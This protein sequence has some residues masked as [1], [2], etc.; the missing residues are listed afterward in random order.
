MISETSDGICDIHSGYQAMR[1][2]VHS[3]VRDVLSRPGTSKRNRKLQSMY[4][5]TN[6][7]ISLS[8]S[9]VHHDDDDPPCDAD[10]VDTIWQ[11][12]TAAIQSA[13]LTNDHDTPQR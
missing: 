12:R 11:V 7:L 6:H 2:A 1:V 5:H 13:P 9:S 10:V 8:L 3:F 4:L